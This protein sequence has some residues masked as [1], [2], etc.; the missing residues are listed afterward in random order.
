MEELKQLNMKPSALVESI[1][2]LQNAA[3]LVTRKML[4][5]QE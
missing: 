3:K 2:S 5:Q 1:A 4:Q